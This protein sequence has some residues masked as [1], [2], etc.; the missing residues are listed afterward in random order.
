M[1]KLFKIEETKNVVSLEHHIETHKEL[2]VVSLESMQDF[3]VNAK[4]RISN[5]FM[6][7]D[8]LA[9]SGFYKKTHNS[10]HR[11]IRASDNVDKEKL[12]S[13]PLV[14]PE[15]FVGELVPFINDMN[16]AYNFILDGLTPFLE[17]VKVDLSTSINNSNERDFTQPS[18]IVAARKN[19][20]ERELRNKKLST[21]FKANAGNHASFKDVMRSTLDVEDM[22][23]AMEKLSYSFNSYTDRSV[24]ST[25]KE[26]SDLTD[27]YVQVL[28]NRP[29]STS[30]HALAGRELTEVLLEAAK[31]IEFLGYLRANTMALFKLVNDISTAIESSA[32]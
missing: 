20:K 27:T 15:G 29:N 9:V 26:I 30:T 18:S 3:F 11:I 5:I 23:M 24:A 25:V 7:E 21:Y 1:R 28:A 32:K 19:R 22:F 10:R 12:N 17:A 14:V 13:F 2:N 16:D 31:G 8:D 4:A 6:G